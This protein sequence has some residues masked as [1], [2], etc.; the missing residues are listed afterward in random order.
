MRTRGSEP[1]HGC[2]RIEIALEKSCRTATVA[3]DTH[4]GAAS[5]TTRRS[6]EERKGRNTITAG[7]VVCLAPET[8]PEKPQPCLQNDF[9][10]Q[11]YTVSSCPNFTLSLLA[12]GWCMCCRVCMSGCPHSATARIA[13]SI[14]WSVRY[15]TTYGYR[16]AI[17]VS[18][19]IAIRQGPRSTSTRTALMYE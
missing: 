10:S 12:C 17:A 4:R 14:C 16:T 11:L 9:V 15:R 8:R 19:A 6:D 2:M 18:R 3:V 13:R 1:I 5:H 7:C